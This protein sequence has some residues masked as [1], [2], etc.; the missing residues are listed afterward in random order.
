M[1][2]PRFRIFRLVGL[3]AAAGALLVIGS[4]PDVDGLAHRNPGR[5]S[6][7]T[8]REKQAR[9]AGQRLKSLLIWKDLD[10]MSPDLVHA[11]LLAEDDTF[12]QHQGFDWKQIE[13]A[14]RTNLEKKRYAYGGS[15]ITQQLAR[16]LYLTPKKSLWRKVREAAI[17]W[18][19]ERALSKKRI[20]ELYLNVV[21]WGKGVYG[22]EAAARTYF[23]KSA[24]ELTPDEAVS[25][26][27]VLPSPRRWSPLS[28]KAFM[29]RRRTQLLERMRRAGY[30]PEEPFESPEY[31]ADLDLS[32]NGS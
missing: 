5:T 25:L 20:L 23:G 12:Y 17:T 6:L 27:S 11:V 24:L 28:E 4:L 22:A 30:L 2:A 7:M 14:V 8:L 9:A 19:L 15:T 1:A 31:P 13:I 3:T 16:T 21:E 29:A 10:A 18:Q 26:A 32:L